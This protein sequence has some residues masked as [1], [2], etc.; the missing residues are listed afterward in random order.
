MIQIC[1]LYV[2]IKV[3]NIFAEFVYA[4][5]WVCVYTQILCVCVYLQKS[6]I[7]LAY[8]TNWYIYFYILLQFS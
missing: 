6:N 5:M 2:R 1:W 4:F 8:D 7:L 3:I